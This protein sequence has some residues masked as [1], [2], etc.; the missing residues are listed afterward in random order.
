MS[1]SLEFRL[2]AVES[3][4]GAALQAAQSDLH[5]LAVNQQELH[6]ENQDIHQLLGKVMEGIQ[7]LSE[8]LALLESKGENNA[9]S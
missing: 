4:V 3:K 5:K 9:I 1:E 6:A 8:R 2:K 7:V